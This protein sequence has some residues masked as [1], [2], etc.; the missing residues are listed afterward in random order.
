MTLMRP[1][2]TLTLL[3]SLTACTTVPEAGPAQSATAHLMADCEINIGNN[4]TL[5]APAWM[6]DEPAP[7]VLLSAVDSAQGGSRVP[8]SFLKTQ[9]EAKA[10]G[11]LARRFSARVASQV[12]VYVAAT[13]A[14]NNDSLDAFS[15]DVTTV[16]SQTE[17]VGAKRLKSREVPINNGNDVRVYV[18]MG[19]DA[20]STEQAAKQALR[21]S[22]KRDRQ[23]WEKLRQAKIRTSQGNERARWQKFTAEEAFTEMAKELAEQAAR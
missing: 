4:A 6:C 1:L 23:M 5:Q 16:L 21:A 3:S 10:M 13:G 14:Y 11:Q 7:G 18:L 15:Q 9:A 19:I 17:L 2:L 22:T 20:D 8:V 12:K